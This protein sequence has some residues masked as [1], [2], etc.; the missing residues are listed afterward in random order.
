MARHTGLALN[1]DRRLRSVFAQEIAHGLKVIIIL[2]SAFLTAVHTG[3]EIFSRSPPQYPHA[4][5]IPLERR[6]DS[7][8][9]RAIA[10]S[11]S[12]LSVRPCSHYL[13]LL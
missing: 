5:G 13:C 6:K 11:L 1:N 2:S 10:I 7:L 3:R 9:R 8:F 12:A 4:V